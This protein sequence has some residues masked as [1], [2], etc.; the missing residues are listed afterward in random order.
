[1]RRR[2]GQTAVEPIGVRAWPAEPRALVSHTMK[3]EALERL[4][5]DFGVVHATPMDSSIKLCRIAE[6]A[7]DLYKRTGPTMEWDTCAG[8]AILQAAGGR[9]TGLDGETFV[10]GKVD[11]KLLNP[12]FIARG[13]L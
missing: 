2:F 12:G 9:F 1:V 5:A 6:G 4:K 13:A 3:P 7:A 10:Y 11:E 8:Q